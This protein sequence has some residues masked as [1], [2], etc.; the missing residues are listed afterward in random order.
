M[1]RNSRA[2]TRRERQFVHTSGSAVSLGL[3]ASQRG[4]EQLGRFVRGAHSVARNIGRIWRDRREYQIANR[5]LEPEM[6][7]TPMPQANLR[8]STSGVQ[9]NNDGSTQRGS[10][11]ST[12]GRLQTPIDG[13]AAHVIGG[14]HLVAAGQNRL[15]PLIMKLGQVPKLPDSLGNM[16]KF[17]NGTGKVVTEFGGVLES[18]ANVRNSTFNVFR[19]NFFDTTV[20]DGSISTLIKQQKYPVGSL[21]LY[22]QAGGQETA[23]GS[24]ISKLPGAPPFSTVDQANPYWVQDKFSNFFVPLNRPDYEDMSWNLN[25]LKLGEYGWN[26]PQAQA[27]AQANPDPWLNVQGDAASLLSN[28]HRGVS[29]IWINN[30][31]HANNTSP[32]NVPAVYSNNSPYKYNM[33]FKNGSCVYN[34]M[35]KGDGPLVATIVVYKVKKNAALIDNSGQYLEGAAGIFGMMSEPIRQGVRDKFIKTNGTDY[36]SN[37]AAT[38]VTNPNTPDPFLDPAAEYMPILPETDKHKFPFKEMQRINF[39][40]PSGGRRNVSL[41]F[42]GDVYDPEGIPWHNISSKQPRILDEHS[43]I[44]LISTHGGKTTR[45]YEQ[46]TGP[47]YGRVGDM[48]APSMLQWEARYTEDINACSYKTPKRQGIFVN[49]AL[50]KSGPVIDGESPVTMLPQDMATG[51]TAGSAS[52]GTPGNV[53]KNGSGHS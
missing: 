4:R 8:G 25:R 24:G 40:L 2:L 9:Q 33:V 14:S 29:N 53:V 6:V 19:H 49:G 35:N 15:P 28:A 32:P 46:S 17:V 22:P 50:A 26:D 51:V 13:S 12:S 18:L 30:I 10:T 20:L 45:Y 39:A 27:G 21:I 36:I 16:L 48:F 3:L 31:K 7:D 47:H 34:F 42:G 5:R 37:P 41:K 43:Y 38:T 1:P 11:G 23:T 44:V 52:L